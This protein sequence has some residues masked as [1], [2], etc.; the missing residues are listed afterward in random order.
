MA[1]PREGNE[2]AG[3]QGLQQDGKRSEVDGVGIGGRRVTRHQMGW[4]TCSDQMLRRS[5]WKP[6]N[7]SC[8]QKPLPPCSIVTAH[9]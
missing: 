6:A 3:R 1:R 7:S 9:A 2:R 4:R 5:L 8:S